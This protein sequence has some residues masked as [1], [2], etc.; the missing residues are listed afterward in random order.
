M[1]R[2]RFAAEDLGR[3]R[4]A[5]RPHALWETV[6]SLQALQTRQRTVLP[7][8]RDAARA[9]LAT[10]HASAALRILRPLVPAHGYFPDFLTPACGEAIA[11]GIAAVRSTPHRRVAAELE[12]LAAGGHTSGAGPATATTGPLASGHGLGHLG[13]ALAYY[14]HAALG[15]YLSRM[16]ALV[17]ADRAVRAR[18]LLDGGV[19]ALLGTM[20]PVLRWRPPV[21]EADYPVEQE[22]SLDG[23]G[24][25]LVPA[26]FCDRNPITLLDPSLPPTLVYPVGDGGGPDPNECAGA[27]AALIGRTRGEVLCRLAEAGAATGELA[28]LL[29]ISAASASQHASVLRRSG[30]VVSRRDG[31][32]VVHHIT[33]L[34]TALLRGGGHPGG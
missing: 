27:L 32:A 19:E 7:G 1:L 21:L 9:R 10:P 26:V 24:L 18:A 20:R 25:L 3:V 12:L 13:D 17:D 5:R 2:I 28:R 8:W 22:L 29:D 33:P 6:L 4:V 30:L 11:D 14:H 23:R 31:S 34:G 16:R 15:P